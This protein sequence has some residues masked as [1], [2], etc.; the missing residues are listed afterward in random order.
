MRSRQHSPPL[1]HGCIYNSSL[2]ITSIHVDVISVAC[3]YLDLFIRE[4][5]GVDEDSSS[6]EVGHDFIGNLL[7]ESTF[8]DFQ[9][10][11]LCPS[12]AVVLESLVCC[13]T[14]GSGVESELP[15]ANDFQ[16]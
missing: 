12:F 2:A 7:F 4:A 6:I 13:S 5:F 8:G 9:P 11:S 15:A 1:T 3:K 16:R 14:T 10:H